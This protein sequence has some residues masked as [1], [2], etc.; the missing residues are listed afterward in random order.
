MWKKNWISFGSHHLDTNYIIFLKCWMQRNSGTFRLS[1][2][3]LQKMTLIIVIQLLVHLFIAAKACTEIWVTTQDKSTEVIGPTPH[4]G[5]PGVFFTR[6]IYPLTAPILIMLTHHF[7]TGQIDT[8]SSPQCLRSG[9]CQW[10]NEQRGIDC[11][12]ALFTRLY[13][14]PGTYLVQILVKPIKRTYRKQMVEK[15]KKNVCG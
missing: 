1:S 2:A 13:Q 9:C 15:R 14:V 4:S 6:S 10:W 11:G 7:K 12:C 8:P 3:S 5:T